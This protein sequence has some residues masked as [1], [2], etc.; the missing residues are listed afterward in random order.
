MARIKVGDTAGE[1]TA[2]L[3]EMNTAGRQ[4]DDLDRKLKDLKGTEESEAA[5]ERTTAG[6]RDSLAGATDNLTREIGRSTS[7]LMAE[8]AE[9]KAN[10]EALTE[11]LRL[12]REIGSAIT[13][14]GTRVAPVETVAAPPSRGVAASVAA[15]TPAELAAVRARE[16]AAYAAA[17]QARNELS[18]ARL[19]GSGSTSEQVGVLAQQRDDTAAAARAARSERVALERAAA[20]AQADAAAMQQKAE[21]DARAAEAAARDAA[22]LQSLARQREAAL[23]AAAEDQRVLEI[24]NMVFRGQVPA[25]YAGFAPGAVSGAA[26]QVLGRP[27]SLAPIPGVGGGRMPPLLP[28][29]PPV[30]LAGEGPED[31]ARYEA[32]ARNTSTAMARL[33]Q[34]QSFANRAFY[35]A[36]AAYADASD[37]L[38]RHGALTTEFIGALARGQVTMAEFGQQMTA[39]IGKFAGWAVAGGAVYAA[40]GAISDLGKGIVQTQSGVQ[41]LGR[42]I[43]GLGG[44]AGGGTGQVVAAG[45][46]L[47]SISLQFNVPIKEV[48]EAM[49]LTARAFHNLADAGNA[50][51]AVLAANKLDQV[52]IQ[53]ASQYL[54]GISQAAGYVGAG[55]P[56]QNASPIAV[57]NALNELQNRFGARVAQTLPGVARA[58]AAAQAGG[59]DQPAL[60]A[61]VGMGVR[62]G[63]TGTAV[64]T[65]L[66]RSL[67]NFMITGASQLQL[68]MLG[69][70]ATPGQAGTTFRNVFGYIDRLRG[71]VR[72]GE[73]SETQAGTIM[74]RIALSIG[75]P[76]L[77]ARTILPLLTSEYNAPGLFQRME[78][79]AAAPPSYQRDLSQVLG[80]LNERFKSIG[81]SLQALGSELG[82]IG[83][84]T[85]LT[86]M[87]TVVTDVT[88]SLMTLLSPLTAITHVISE[89]PGPL[90]DLLGAACRGPGD[91]DDCAP[92]HARRRCDRVAWPHAAWC[93]LRGAAGSGVRARVAAASRN[94]PDSRRGAERW[95]GGCAIQDNGRCVP[96]HDSDG[97]VG[98]GACRSGGAHGARRA[99]VRAGAAA[100]QR[101]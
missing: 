74:R 62:Q 71:D 4:L 8:T 14:G 87:V 85:V 61:L 96:H 82:Q 25:S 12:R 6:I 101:V 20:S 2:A 26:A 33:A 36:S 70:T 32:A 65:A 43:P 24:R 56:A 46:L 52:G 59:L 30:G 16:T 21:A 9:W 18:Q 34:Q 69:I 89:L 15:V 93:Q 1:V 49:G 78:A 37:R 72:G 27:A 19:K 95:Q 28:P 76:Q 13:S 17:E 53:Q 98:G 86:G 68:Q 51:R 57:F 66:S 3:T 35:E 22:V 47:R 92:H 81:I 91:T 29:G 83:V 40:F 63:Q 11:N 73:L 5:T 99:S 39:T 67:T 50:A 75:G 77:G 10:N 94:I 38:S 97:R 44:P 64:G 54:I 31:L 23:A 58:E 84:T 100:T 79:R 41:N 90:R 45:D 80:Q 42:F 88:R 60:E 7:A 48:G 55:G